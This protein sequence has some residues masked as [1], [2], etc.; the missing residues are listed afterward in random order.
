L[1]PNFNLTTSNIPF[2]N[3]ERLVLLAAFEASY[4]DTIT[5][6][7]PDMVPIIIDPGASVSISPYS[8][9]FV[10]PINAVQNV[11][12]QGIASGLQAAGI[13]TIQYKFRNDADKEKSLLL[14]RCLHV[15]QC[16]V[17][18]LCP[19]QIGVMTGFPNDGFHATSAKPT[20]IVQGKSTTIA[21]DMTSNLPLIF[22]T[23][24]I[25]SFKRFHANVSTMK[26][27]PVH[28]STTS[29]N[30]MK[31]QRRKLYLHE[32]CAHEGFENL[33][34]W[35]RAGRFPG[36]DASL[37]NIPDPQCITCNFGKAR[38]KSH[39]SNVG[40]ISADH[41]LPRDGVSSD[42]ME[43]GTPDRPFTTK[44][45]PSTTHFKYASFWVDH[46]SSLVYA[47]FHP[48]KAAT[49]LLRSKE[50]F[51]AWAARFNVDI[52]SIRADNGVCAAQSFKDSCAKKRQRLT[53]CAAGTHWQNGIA[54]RFIGTITKR[55][56]TILLHAMH[57]WPSVIHEE[58]WPFAIQHAVA[59]HNAS[60]RKDQSQCPHRRFTGEDPPYTVSDFRVFGSPAY[61][62]RKEL[63]DGN[64]LSKW[65]SRSWQGVYVGHSTCHSGSIPLIYNPS[66]THIMP[67][68]HII[69]D[70]YF[71]TI[72]ETPGISL[73]NRLDSLFGTSAHWTYTDAYTDDP[74]TFQSFWTGIHDPSLDQSFATK[75]KRRLQSI[76]PFSLYGLQPTSILRHNI[77]RVRFQPTTDMG[78]RGSPI[79]NLPHSGLHDAIVASTQGT[80]GHCPT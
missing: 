41:K 63:Q 8:M 50:E 75:R 22:T 36:V 78:S 68:Y 65:S 69:Y 79:T 77:R 34:R 38:R 5:P 21:Y 25:S 74:Y 48:T 49:E 58:L 6:L 26:T 3:K 28:P 66:T 20:L 67:Q 42:G 62:L 56:R 18:L 61:V 51:E 70:E 73:D 45:Q 80:P 54:E 11:N 14:R 43:A 30:L 33:N 23:P 60:V 15:P 9:D 24:G 52:K 64:K 10:G 16:S 47:T 37:A 57:R 17:R 46:A 55:A 71:Q 1:E 53:C 32:C 7:T 59:F 39:K 72:N 40:H 31:L 4:Q 29:L 19:Q 44:G 13:G 76:T 2:S 35:I 27:P 12:L